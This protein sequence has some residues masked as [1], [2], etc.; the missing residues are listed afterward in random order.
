ME[1]N[2]CYTGFFQQGSGILPPTSAS[3]K[4]NNNSDSKKQQ[5]NSHTIDSSD[6]YMPTFYWSD[7]LLNVNRLGNESLSQQ[8]LTKIYESVSLW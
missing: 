1:T 8:G 6:D 2:L 7:S 3:G 4:N 5:F